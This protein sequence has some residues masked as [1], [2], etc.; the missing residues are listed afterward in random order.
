MAMMSPLQ[1]EGRQFESGRA[2]LS[3]FVFSRQTKQEFITFLTNKNYSTKHFR[4][5]ISTLKSVYK[6]GSLNIDLDKRFVKDV[7]KRKPS[8]AM[9]LD[10]LRELGKGI[11]NFSNIV[12]LGDREEDETLSKNL[13]AKFID[14]KGKKYD[15]ILSEIKKILGE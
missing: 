4:M 1:G 8:T 7:T 3:T 9:V 15:D 6:N 5:C 12:V 11:E 10:S 13:N 2:H 14:V